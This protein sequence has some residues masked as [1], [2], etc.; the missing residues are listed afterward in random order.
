MDP[1]G[2]NS[3]KGGG[4]KPPQANTGTKSHPKAPG[5]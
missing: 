1:Y 4:N 2:K 5:K 3:N